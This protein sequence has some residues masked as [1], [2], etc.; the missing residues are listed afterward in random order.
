M[1]PRTILAIG[2]PH[3]KFSNAAESA[4]LMLDIDSFLDSL[5]PDWLV[6]LGDILDAHRNADLVP[7]CDATRWI[8]ELSK[9]I[10]TFVLIGNHDRINNSD[11]LSGYHPFPGLEGWP[12]LEIIYQAKLIEGVLFVPYVKNGRFRDA[13]ETILPY[14]EVPNKME[15]GFAH[16]EFK[17]APLG[18]K[19][20]MIPEEWPSSYPLL[21]SGHIH[22]ACMVGKNLVY[23]GSAFSHNTGE[24]DKKS[25][26]FLSREETNG[27][28]TSK[29]GEGGAVGLWKW[30]RIPLN[31]VVRKV[32]Y[33]GVSDAIARLGELSNMKSNELIQWRVSGTS[34][35][36]AS[37]IRRPEIRA[38]L[39]TGRFRWQPE[40][41]PTSISTL[42]G[43]KLP[44]LPQSTPKIAFS[45]EMYSQLN[46][47]PLANLYWNTFCSEH[48]L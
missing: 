10:R 36:L 43:E 18:H 13:I 24:L 42:P 14:E 25:V 16:Q 2:D 28:P 9:K 32:E 34:A 46:S 11:F 22:L 21:I 4:Q 41:L 39:A 44:L 45:N 33:L 47:N 19:T 7:L 12:N 31:I 48:A 40:P 27:N 5:R 1:S 38:A 30:E 15:V 37:A 26:V 6:L 29:D 8:K 23:S 17:G 3:F 20:S 35:E